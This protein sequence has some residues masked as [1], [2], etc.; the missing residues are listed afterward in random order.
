MRRIFPLLLILLLLCGCGGNRDRGKRPQ[1]CRAAA[2][3]AD[4][5]VVTSD[6]PRGENP[7]AILKDI[8][9]GMDGFDTPFAVIENRRDAT[10]F[11]LEQARAGDVVLL[12]G[13]GHE[14]YQIIGDTVYPYDEKK[15]VQEL[16]KGLKE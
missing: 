12:A 1:M 2:S 8:L 5:M 11:A 3:Y 13:K 6:N 15:I 14:D 9:A 16:I 10:K 7:Y 4:F